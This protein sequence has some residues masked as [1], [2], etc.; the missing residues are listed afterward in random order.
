MECKMCQHEVAKTMELLLEHVS[1]VHSHSSN[2]QISCVVVG[3]QRTYWNY[4]SFRRHLREAHKYYSRQPSNTNQTPFTS[5]QLSNEVDTEDGTEEVYD[6]E[7]PTKRQRAKWILKVRETKKITQVCTE[8]ILSDVTHLCSSIVHDLT[9][10]I[11][12]KLTSH[13]APPELQE[14]MK[15]LETPRFS[16]PFDGLETHY[17]QMQYL[18][19]HF[20]FVVSFR[21]TCISS[22]KCTHIKNIVFHVQFLMVKDI[23][24]I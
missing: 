6:I 18:R 13:N 20:N 2:F 19:E 8:N 23:D 24:K 12:H 9:A 14:D 1:R 7:P 11:K 10:A 3:C 16:K 4:A 5:H 15:V 21:L 17:K 22:N